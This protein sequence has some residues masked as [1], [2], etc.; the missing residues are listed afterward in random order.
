MEIKSEEKA[1]VE[2]V[3]EEEEKNKPLQVHQAEVVGSDGDMPN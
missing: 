3:K 1:K 2:E